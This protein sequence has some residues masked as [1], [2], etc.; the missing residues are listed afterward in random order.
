VQ[1]RYEDGR[2][3]ADGAQARAILQVPQ[4]HLPVLAGTQQIAVVGG[5]AQRLDLARVAAQLACDAIR[6]DVE[7]DYDA[8]VLARLACCRT[9]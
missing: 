3:E 7:E 4:H 6:L 5:P 2:L 9:E 8:V 1:L